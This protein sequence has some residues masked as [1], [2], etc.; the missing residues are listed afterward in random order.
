MNTMSVPIPT[1][2]RSSASVI[3]SNIVFGTHRTGL[4]STFR[5]TIHKPKVPV[6]SDKNVARGRRDNHKTDAGR[7]ESVKAVILAAGEGTRLRPRTASKPKPLVEVAGRPLLARAFE[8][9]DDCGI[10]EAVV[11][12]GYEGDRI[13]DRYGDAHGD[14]DVEYARQREPTGLAH[15]VLAASPFVDDDIVVMNGDN[16]YGGGLSAAL[17]RHAAT[18]ADLTFLTEE[19]TR[20]QAGGGAVCAFENG[21]LVGLVEKPDDPPSTTVAV[22]FYVLPP[23]IIPACR[24]VTPSERG[25]YE[26]PD[27]IDLLLRAGYA[28][29]TVPFEG[30]RVNVNTE[31]DLQEAEAMLADDR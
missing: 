14:I 4:A 23:E 18:D 7:P 24:L 8:T 28:A 12:V 20:A 17:A 29:E 13:V 30:W 5:G 6:I 31:D 19:T 2:P 3:F 15:A 25:E 11:V 16:V 9:L 27:A 10:E 22:P 26:L 21:D 1:C